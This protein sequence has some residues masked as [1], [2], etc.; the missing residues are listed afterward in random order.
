[1]SWNRFVMGFLL[2]T[3]LTY[4]KSQIT[5]YWVPI[6]FSYFLIF[7]ILRSC[8]ERR[9]LVFTFLLSLGLD[10][11]LQVGLIKGISAASQLLLIYL[12]M[13]L[14]QNVVPAF[15]DFFLLTFF[16]IFYVVNYY[17][18]IGLSQVLGSPFQYPQ[19]NLIQL[20]F[21][22][23]FHTAFFGLLLLIDIRRTARGQSSP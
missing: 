23:F 21:L 4:A 1:M 5:T 17:L 14:K 16:A 7:F 12:I 18:C 3:L 8:S 11:V 19:T 15:H 22:A 20:L 13:K 10:L 9:A 2:V 6:E